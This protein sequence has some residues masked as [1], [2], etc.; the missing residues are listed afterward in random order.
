MA[1]SCSKWCWSDIKTY[2]HVKR[3]LRQT[4]QDLSGLTR[5]ELE[6]LLQVGAFTA[7]FF[8]F[9]LVQAIFNQQT[10]G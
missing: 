4:N 10:T 9:T 7:V 5:G 3:R 2:Y 8:I 1:F 6:V